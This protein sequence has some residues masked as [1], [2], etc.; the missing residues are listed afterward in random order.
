MEWQKLSTSRQ[1]DMDCH[2]YDISPLY[3]IHKKIKGVTGTDIYTSTLKRTRD[4][5][6]ALFGSRT[7]IETKL[8]NEVPLKSFCDSRIP[9]PLLVWNVIGRLQWGMGNIRQP[10]GR[11]D[12]QRRANIL[13]EELIRKNRDCVL[14]SHGFFMRILIKELK[15][16]GFKINKRRMRLG[17][18]DFVLASREEWMA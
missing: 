18:L 8:L 11:K 13:I 5:A 4:T 12:S 17:N 14:V 6:E 3:P 2:K 16:Y 7:F 1:F 10:E 9:L 15:R